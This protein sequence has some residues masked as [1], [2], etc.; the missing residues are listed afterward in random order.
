[1][2]YPKENYSPS[3]IGYDCSQPASGTSRVK[4]LTFRT[5]KFSD[6]SVIQIGMRTTIIP[7]ISTLLFPN[8]KAENM[9]Y[10]R[11]TFF[12]CT[13]PMMAQSQKITK[14]NII[15]ETLENN[16]SPQS[17]NSIHLVFTFTKLYMDLSKWSYCELNKWNREKL[18]PRNLENCGDLR[19]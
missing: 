1:M 9:F 4:W 19:K 10:L 12:A 7:I 18:V 3:S 17:E 2:L 6:G 14:L 16:A 13:K 5:S 11:D 8:G 15:S